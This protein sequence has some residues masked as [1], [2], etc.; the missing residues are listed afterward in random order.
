MRHSFVNSAQLSH[1]YLIQVSL[2]YRYRWPDRPPGPSPT[3]ARFGPARCGP[4]LSG[5]KPL[6][7]RAV[8]DH[9]AEMLAQALWPFDSARPARQPSWPFVLSV[10]PSTVKDGQ[11][12]HPPAPTAEDGDPCPMP[13]RT[14]PCITMSRPP[15]CP[16][17]SRMPPCP[18]PSRTLHWTTPLQTPPCPTPLR[19]PLCIHN[20]NARPWPGHHSAAWIHGRRRLIEEGGGGL[21]P[22]EVEALPAAVVVKAWRG[23]GLGRRGKRLAAVVGRREMRKKVR[24]VVFIWMVLILT[25]WHRAGP[26]IVTCRPPCRG[27]CPDPVRPLGRAGPRHYPLRVGPF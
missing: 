4:T 16:M 17:P 25:C 19:P 18:T 6:S 7:C 13:S 24:V 14:L 2:E 8:S 9:R 3:R 15:P 22:P 12:A 21:G 23:S 10:G 5:P 27:C 11:P 20:S 1:L 26:K